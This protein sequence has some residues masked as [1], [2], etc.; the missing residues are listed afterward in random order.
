MPATRPIALVAALAA[1]ACASSTP[2]PEPPMTM[3]N[4][5]AESL[6]MQPVKTWPLKF[7]THSFSVK[8]Y[9][10]WGARVT[11]AGWDRADEEDDVLQPSSDS[12]GPNWQRG[13]SGTFSGIRNFPPPAQLKW[14]SKD[15]KP[16]QA[17]I[18][19][20]AIFADEVIRHNVQRDE[21]AL[22]PNGRYSREPAVVLEIND[23]M[24]RV[25]MLAHIPLRREVNVSGVMRNDVRYE[26]VLVKTYNF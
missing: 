12:Y 16:L 23:R 1:S 8:T 4:A 11:Y 17:E 7:R 10:T 18:D 5:T 2:A 3:P 19:I 9:D 24:V 20:G 25:W 13:W 15:G 22:Q 6:D 21:M 26:P 14:R